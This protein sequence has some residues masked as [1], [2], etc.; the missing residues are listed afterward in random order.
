MK[1]QIRVT[2]G[3]PVAGLKPRVAAADR[4][5]LDF[6]DPGFVVDP[7]AAYRRLRERAPVWR[8]PWG[9]WVLTR[10]SDIAAVLKSPRFGRDFEEKLVNPGH[11]LPIF[12]EPAYRFLALSML[13]RDPPD[14]TRLRALVCKAFTA[15]RVEA[16]RPRIEAKVDELLDAIIPRRHMEVMADL[17]RMLP[18][19]VICDML[20][21]QEGERSELL[22]NYRFAGGLLDPKPKSTQEIAQQNASALWVRAFFEEMFQR[23]MRAPG[24][25]LITA[26]LQV[27]DDASGRL[28]HDELASNLTLLFEA[29]H[30]T[31]TNLIGNGLLALHRDPSQWA[32]LTARP[33]LAAGAVEELLRY[34]PPV[35]M[36]G[37]KAFEDVALPGGALIRY[38]ERVLCLL[39]A[40]NRDPEVHRDPDRLDITRPDPAPMS[41]GGGIHH[42]LGAQLARIEGEIV[43]RRLAERLPALTLDDVANPRW[44]PTVAL[45]GLARLDARW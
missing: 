23:R 35:Q 27:R 39:G 33:Q 5:R 38:R 44:Q 45:R 26:L 43:F 28:S 30:A 29:G 12:D 2:F 16:M 3:P 19:I 17:A 4:P 34:E 20:G 32:L 15:R 8:A 14:H 40:A 24:D 7:Y 9:E 6:A 41:F 18:I 13:V 31:S 1:P 10:H 37:R 25:D 22:T 11:R 21:I 36:T 42:C